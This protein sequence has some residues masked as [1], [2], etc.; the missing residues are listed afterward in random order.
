MV[1]FNCRHPL[2]GD[3]GL[4][5]AWL[6]RGKNKQQGRRKKKEKEGEPRRVLIRKTR[7]A[8]YIPVRQLTGTRTDRYRAV[9]LRSAVGGRFP[10]S[11][12]GFCRLRRCCPS[13]IAARAALALSPPAGFFLPMRERVQGDITEHAGESSRRLGNH[14]ELLDHGA[15]TCTLDHADP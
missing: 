1:D 14:L 5:I 12:V 4:A 11:M 2:P 7:T 6:R 15:A 8:R 9:P 10:P 3:I 13:A